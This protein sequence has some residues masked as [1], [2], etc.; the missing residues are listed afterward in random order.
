MVGEV[1]SSEVLVVDEVL[2]VGR[3]V[4]AGVVVEGVSGISMT[5]N[6]AL[7]VDEVVVDG[8]TIAG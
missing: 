4:V 3:H 8:R 5:F 2:V 6:K 1:P 7:D